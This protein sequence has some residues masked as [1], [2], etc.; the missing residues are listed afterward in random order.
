M[1]LTELLTKQTN[2]DDTFAELM[3]FHPSWP[4]PEDHQPPSAYAAML[5]RTAEERRE[6]LREE[7]LIRNKKASKL[8]SST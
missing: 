5:E 3:Y 1:E 8:D 4:L 2:K 7:R 6:M